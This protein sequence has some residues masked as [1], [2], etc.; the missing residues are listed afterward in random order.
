MRQI[1]KIFFHW[2]WLFL[3]ITLILFSV[4]CYIFFCSNGSV[5]TVSRNEFPTEVK[6][7]VID[8]RVNNETHQYLQYMTSECKNNFQ[9]I[10]WESC[11]YCQEKERTLNKK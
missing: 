8:I 1:D 6:G 5:V 10:H 4:V 3:V 9:L 11:K 2:F 7:Q